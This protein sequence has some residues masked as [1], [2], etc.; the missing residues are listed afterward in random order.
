VGERGAA[1]A[2]AAPAPVVEVIG[3]AANPGCWLRL[4]G[5]SGA[6]E[7]PGQVLTDVTRYFGMLDRPAGPAGK[8]KRPR[9]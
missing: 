3:S 2:A 5:G 4:V 6:Q 8:A 9:R 7:N 1:H